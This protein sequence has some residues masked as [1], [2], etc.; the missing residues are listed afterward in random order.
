MAKAK[1]TTRWHEFDF[2]Q[3]KTGDRGEVMTAFCA[4][5]EI[6]EIVS[7]FIVGNKVLM[8]YLSKTDLEDQTK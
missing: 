3:A 2:T 4:D 1:G 5:N 6:Y 8:G 7:V